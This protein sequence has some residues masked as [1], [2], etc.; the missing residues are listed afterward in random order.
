MKLYVNGDSHT[1]AAEAVNKHSFAHDDIRFIHL[2]H[3]PHPENLEVSWGQ[4][5]ADLLNAQFICDAE[6]AGSNQRILRTCREW[7]A[8]QT[9]TALNETLMIIQWSTWEREEWLHNGTWYQVNA[10][11]VDYVPADLELKY[12]QYVVDVDWDECTD[13]GHREIWMFHHELNFL[14]IKHVFF[15]GNSDFSKLTDKF[16]WGNSYLGPYDPKKTYTNLLKSNN[17]ATISPESWHFGKDAH[18]FWAKHMLQYIVDNKL[19]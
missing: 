5:L 4:Q 19:I 10:S 7:I 14:K 1:A 2:E 16:E 13:R 15:N 3:Q 17:Y 8:N 9:P 6:S 11:G 18:C 12:K